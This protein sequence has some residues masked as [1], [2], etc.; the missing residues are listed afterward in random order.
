MRQHLVIQV[1]V[2]KPAVV[3]VA[4][5]VIVAV[6]AQELKIPAKRK[7][8][9]VWRTHIESVLV[10][11]EERI[12]RSTILHLGTDVFA[13]YVEVRKRKADHQPVAVGFLPCRRRNPAENFLEGI[14][15]I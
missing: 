7:A 1:K 11:F 15:E 6:G 12:R 13:Q 2:H 5:D 14:G 3:L 4:M 8:E 10:I 9:Q